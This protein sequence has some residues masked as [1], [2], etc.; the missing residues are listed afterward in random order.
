MSRGML[1]D[2]TNRN[3]LEKLMLKYL[4]AK[5]VQQALK[6]DPSSLNLIRDELDNFLVETQLHLKSLSKEVRC[7]MTF[8]QVQNLLNNMGLIATI[9]RNGK[10]IATVKAVVINGQIITQYPAVMLLYSKY[11]LKNDL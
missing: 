10:D 4:L 3:K 7:M 8:E 1:L 11:L 9:A 6:E 2:S 5:N